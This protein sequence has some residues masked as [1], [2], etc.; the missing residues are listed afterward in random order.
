L[1]PLK[2][3]L[4]PW[5]F[6]DFYKIDQ[7]IKLP[8]VTLGVVLEKLNLDYVD[9][10]KIDSQGTDLRILESLGETIIGKILAAEL[11]PGIMDTY[12]GE[13]KIYSVLS[14]MDKRDFWMSGFE[15][16]GS[17]YLPRKFREN[18]FSGLERKVLPSVMNSAPGW[19]EIAFL[20][21]FASNDFNKRD[22]MLGYILA[23][24]EKQFGF[25][26]EVA[27][28]GRERFGDE[29]FNEMFAYALGKIKRKCYFSSALFK[30][31]IYKLLG[32]KK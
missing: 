31:I 15:I 2:D 13:D 21:K 32:K 19:T 26:L 10:F 1:E 17:Q 29:I 23:L 4:D 28:K 27:D 9:W 3:A 20:N 6:A 14:F 24:I 11:E 30:K 25:A 18:Y 16:Y 12:D 7:K 5:M 8:S 22:F